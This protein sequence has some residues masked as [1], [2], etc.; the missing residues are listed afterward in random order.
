MKLSDFK[1]EIRNVAGPGEPPKMDAWQTGSRSNL[2]GK[3]TCGGKLYQVKIHASE[4][5]WNLV[6]KKIRD[7]KA[8]LRACD[9]SDDLTKERL[10]N[11]IASLEKNREKQNQKDK[12]S[13]DY[14][15]CK[16]RLIA[17]INGVGSSQ[18]VC[19]VAFWT[20]PVEEKGNG[21]FAIE[22]VPWITHNVGF[23]GSEPIDFRRDL[24]LE[25][26]YDVVA[27]FCQQLDKLHKAGV[28]HSDL[29]L[30]NTV[31]SKDSDGLKCTI[32][33]F[34]SA[35][36][37]DDLYS[38]R[39]SVNVW[40]YILG[41]TFFSPELYPL[42]MIC[43]ENKDAAEFAEF[44]KKSITTKSD[45]FALGVTIYEYFFGEA[46]GA[47][48]MP[49]VS[50][51]GEALD[52]PMYGLAVN[53]GYKPNLPDTVNDLLFGALN[54]MLAKDPAERPTAEQVAQV[55]ATRNISLIPAKYVRNPL[56]EEHQGNYKLTLP[57]GVSVVK[58][59]KPRYRLKNGG[60]VVTR[61]IEELVRSGFAVEL[62][63]DG[64]PKK[65][66]KGE[67]LSSKIWE[68]DGEGTLPPCV[69]RA[70]IS[71]RYI[72]HSK[73]LTRGATFAQ[74]KADGYICTEAEKA[75]PWPCD[76]DLKFLG[77]R[78]VLRDF[79]DGKGA[80]CYVVGTG[81]SAV[82]YTTQ[83][84]VER[85]LASTTIYFALCRDDDVTHKPDFSKIPSNVKAITRS[86]IVNHQYRLEYTDGRI[87]KLMIDE[88]EK[89]GYVT[90]K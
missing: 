80:G 57:D 72:V 70:A 12:E 51:D 37:L 47:N 62:G 52:V 18:L 6:D 42:Y 39:Y 90:K 41:G 32:I 63:A 71:G 7:K 50:A 36:L 84:L 65:E 35:I 78:P 67:D 54:W 76:K 64:E 31:V 22:A 53:Q 79:S 87:E 14:V 74:L 27:S 45:I 11:E 2:W 23:D 3:G 16:Q 25:Q 55:F 85:G 86:A 29:K 81:I 10:Q 28:L 30:G 9:P 26:Q 19:P 15:E 48:I 61:S 49:F 20:E 83:M 34:D 21:T 69:R 24:T 1:M 58:A 75:T 4:P 56:W 68:S 59:I 82:R 73:G 33:D 60:V 13:D 66:E 8:E 44:D 38:D 5:K 77:T 88:M 17:A 89:R 43:R 46:D 40:Y